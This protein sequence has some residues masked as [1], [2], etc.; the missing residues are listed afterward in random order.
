M[1]SVVLRP[2]QRPARAR[3]GRPEFWRDNRSCLVCR[4]AFACTM[5]RCKSQVPISFPIPFPITIPITI[6]ITNPIR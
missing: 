4:F 2:G 6:P 3:G 5:G 1:I